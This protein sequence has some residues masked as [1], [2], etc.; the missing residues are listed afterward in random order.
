MKAKI[1]HELKEIDVTIRDDSQSLYSNTYVP[2]PHE[3]DPRETYHE[4]AQILKNVHYV[5][6]VQEKVSACF[7]VL[8]A[9]KW[10][11]IFLDV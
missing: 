6:D 9:V 2:L 3:T 5:R 11:K 8:G 7:I 10:N 1:K 4:R